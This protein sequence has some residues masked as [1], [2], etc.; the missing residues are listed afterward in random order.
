MSILKFLGMT[1]KAPR[2][3]SDTETV[4]RIVVQLEALEP[5]RARYLAAFAYILA[6]VAYADQQVSDEETQRMEQIVVQFGG[7]SQA[8]A[9]LLVQI[10]KAQAG[11]FGGTEDFL[12]TRQFRDVSTPEEREQLLH[13]LFAVSAADDSI[14]SVEESQIRQI[15]SE[16]GFTDHD[17][18]A[19]R[20]QYSD[21]RAVLRNLPGGK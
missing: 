7:L 2:P 3:D 1:P 4:R 9:V 19:V 14:S 12:V 17:F 10:A 21:K 20:L 18:I 11:L 8:Q 13:C 6:R 15:A 5:H 16:I